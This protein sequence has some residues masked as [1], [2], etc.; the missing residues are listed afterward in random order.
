MIYL[1][2]D[3]SS[4]I[5]GYSVWHNKELIE[6][7]KVKF[8]GEFLTRVIELKFWML[9]KIKEF[10]EQVVE[11]VIEEIQ[12]QANAQ[13]F[14]KL[15]M[16]QGVLLVALIE[17]NVKYHLVYSS[18]WKSAAGI[19]GQNRTEQK[20]NTQKYVLEKFNQKVTQ[21]EAD[22]ICMGEYISSTVENWGR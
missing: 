13:T 22:A 5:S 1:S 12:E 3:Q 4:N 14:K 16:L 6:W 18:Q 9:S 19:K 11:V 21:D 20:Q 8:E 2:I 7:G 17:I 10:K 15:A